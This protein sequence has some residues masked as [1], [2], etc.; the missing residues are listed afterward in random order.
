MKSDIETLINS[1]FVLSN[2]KQEILESLMTRLRISKL[3]LIE[4][5]K[6]VLEQNI[7]ETAIK[8]SGYYSKF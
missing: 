7:S 3:N 5:L 2:S 1:L 4:N 6:I 8:N